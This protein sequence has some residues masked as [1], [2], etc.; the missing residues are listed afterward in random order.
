MKVGVPSLGLV[1]QILLRRIELLL[2]DVL[3]LLL[4]L[5]EVASVVTSPRGSVTTVIATRGQGT[6]VAEAKADKRQL[7]HGLT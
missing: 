6:G 4:L 3:L 1:G 5:R 2:R 7:I